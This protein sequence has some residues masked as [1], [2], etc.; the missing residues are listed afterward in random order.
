MI[1]YII[2]VLAALAAPHPMLAQAAPPTPRTAVELIARNVAAGGALTR[3][4]LKRLAT[5]ISRS[6]RDRDDIA[7]R[8]HILRCTVP[9]FA[10]ADRSFIQEVPCN[11]DVPAMSASRCRSR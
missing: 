9:V 8:V 7:C 4:R 5:R 6:S 2:L 1:A 11:F 10:F 3:L